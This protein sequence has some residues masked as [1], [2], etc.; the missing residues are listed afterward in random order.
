VRI[1]DQTLREFFADRQAIRRLYRQ[2]PERFRELIRNGNFSTQPRGG[3]GWIFRAPP[4]TTIVDY[5]LG[6]LMYGY[7]GWQAAL[8]TE[9]DNRFYENCPGPSC[10]G[11]TKFLYNAGYPAAG[12]ATIVARL[13][14]GAAGG[15]P[16]TISRATSG[17]TPQ[18]SRSATPAF[19]ASRSS[20]AACSTAA[21]WPALERW[22]STAATTAASANTAPTSTAISSD[23]LQQLSIA[24]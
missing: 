5:R 10:S 14:C 11:A 12:T 8:F 15:C 2:Q 13:R 22:R 4:G 9:P 3:A 18:V 20:A 24:A 7:N 17:S 6:G 19:P 23:E 1:D 21:G 16:T